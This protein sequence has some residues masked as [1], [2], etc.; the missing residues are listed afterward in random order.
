M[1]WRSLS[2]ILAAAGLLLFVWC[3]AGAFLLP[4]RGFTLQLRVSGSAEELEQS[5]RSAAWLIG[6]G[7]LRAP[8]E[9]VGS[10]LTDEALSR[11]E[12]LARRYPYISI[13]AEDEVGRRT[14][15]DPWERGRGD[16]S[17]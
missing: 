11:C 6:S 13:V 8:L 9:I 3:L 2:C 15:A 7:L 14:R 1:I 16:L 10:G 12:R 17:E 4:A 5:V